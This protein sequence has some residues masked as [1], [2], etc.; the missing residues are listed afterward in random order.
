[1]L[2]RSDFHYRHE[3][4]LYGHKPGPGRIGRGA[5][6]WHA[7]NAEDSVFE[8]PRPRASREHPTAKPAELL[9]R[10]VRN[11]S[12][13]G[14]LVLDPFAGSGST[15]AASESL[16]RRARLL[17]LDPSYADVIVARFE[18]LTGGRAELVR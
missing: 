18:R 14:G 3:G 10:F 8:V 2:G 7:G 12:P 15:L 17:E 13:R 9:A 5:R 4:I 1:M 11:S 16:G 6:G